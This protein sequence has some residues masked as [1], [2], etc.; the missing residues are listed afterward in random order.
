VLEELDG[1][2]ARLIRDHAREDHDAACA[3]IVHFGG[4]RVR[5]EGMADDPKAVPRRGRDVAPAAHGRK[6]TDL[7][8]GME[9]LI[10]LDVVVPHGEEC[11]RAVLGQRGMPVDDRLPRAFDGAVVGQIE[12]E[13]LLPGGFTIPGEEP[14]PDTQLRTSRAPKWPPTP[15]TLRTRRHSPP[16][17]ST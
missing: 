12:L 17:A 16:R 1:P 13:S 9:S 5:R 2:A 3:G 11:E 8:A 4:D 7:V 10:G 6:E 14:D 15:P